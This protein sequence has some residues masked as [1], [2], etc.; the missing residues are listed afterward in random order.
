MGKMNLSIG[1]AELVRLSAIAIEHQDCQRNCKFYDVERG[2]L[3]C[4]NLSQRDNGA[5][6]CYGWREDDGAGDAA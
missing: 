1:A 2:A 3:Y 4:P 5:I 6:S